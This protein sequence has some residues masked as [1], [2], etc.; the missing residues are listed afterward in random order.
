MRA[1]L[2]W[3][4]IGAALVLVVSAGLGLAA[5]RRFGGGVR[6]DSAAEQV[7]ARDADQRPRV[8]VPEASNILVM[9]SAAAVRPPRRSS[10]T[11]APRRRP[12]RR[13]RA[14][15]RPPPRPPPSSCTCPPTGAA[16]PPS[17]CP[18]A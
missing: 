4:A 6:T 7:L 9:G 16:A 15:P 2:R 1:V 17:P 14:R 5:Y 13:P 10:P 3:V 8:L 11:W 12:S 18:A